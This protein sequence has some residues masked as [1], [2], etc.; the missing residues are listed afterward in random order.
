MENNMKRGPEE[1]N[2]SARKSTMEK[3]Q[4]LVK[5][6]QVEER[7][8]AQGME[9]RNRRVE[10]LKKMIAEKEERLRKAK[11]EVEKMD[12][13]LWDK[14]ESVQILL[15]MYR[16]MKREVDGEDHT[17]PQ[18]DDQENTESEVLTTRTTQ[19]NVNASRSRGSP[20]LGKKFSQCQIPPEFTPRICSS[21]MPSPIKH[22]PDV[23]NS[24]LYEQ[25]G[26][27][28]KRPAQIMRKAKKPQTPLKPEKVP[29]L[30]LENLD[31]DNLRKGRSA[32]H[33]DSDLQII[34]CRIGDSDED[35]RVNPA[36][37][38]PGVNII[39]R[40]S[41]RSCSNSADNEDP[42]IQEACNKSSSQQSNLGVATPQQGLR[43]KLEEVK[44][45]IRRESS[46]FKGEMEMVGQLVDGKAHKLAVLH[47]R[48]FKEAILFS[49]EDIVTST[50]PRQSAGQGSLPGPGHSSLDLSS[51][52]SSSL[53][54]H[55]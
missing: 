43:S 23:Y 52:S 54:H 26:V 49:F 21:P 24:P 20:P 48:A 51:L 18:Q 8:F 53:S 9:G 11:D 25:R 33:S 5:E 32:D 14:E 37:V 12:A 46:R 17:L 2:G 7:E 30:D 42:T 6:M 3:L 4:L 13:L 22:L 16:R 15:E 27:Q 55:R 31:A 28:S 36:M 40:G 39:A 29:K 50:L 41:K 1:N 45:A 47:E 10:E 35:V 38:N 34:A 44:Q 19:A